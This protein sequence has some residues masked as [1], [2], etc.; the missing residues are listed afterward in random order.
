MSERKQP[1]VTED[2][3]IHPILG[4]MKVIK[5]DMGD[6]VVCDDCNA[7]YTELPDKG[8]ISF[9]GR[10]ICP[11]CQQRWIQSAEKYNEDGDIIYNDTAKSFADWVREDLR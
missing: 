2:I 7:D 4:E 8:G 9:H 11:E 1:K 3:E 10:A 5:V 6:F